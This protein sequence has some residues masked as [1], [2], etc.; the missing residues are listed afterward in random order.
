M[1]KKI[2]SGM[3]VTVSIVLGIYC[4]MVLPEIVTVQIDPSGNPSNKFPKILAV[5]SP[6]LL[7]IGGALGYY[8]SQDK[9]KK[10]LMLA[11]IGSL[12]PIIT[13]LF[14]K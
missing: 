7:S 5:I 13:L 9:E 11:V 2:I 6:A 8:F 14:N 4:Y 1:N 10:Y 12:L 3:I